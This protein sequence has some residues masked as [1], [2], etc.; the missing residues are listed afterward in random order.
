M[1]APRRPC[2]QPR[3]AQPLREGGGGLRS[4]SCRLL[5]AVACRCLG[6]FVCETEEAPTSCSCCGRRLPCALCNVVC[7]KPPGQTVCRPVLQTSNG[8]LMKLKE[9][10]QACLRSPHSPVAEQRQEPRVLI[11]SF[12]FEGQHFQSIF[13]NV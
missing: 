8:G 5:C 9:K 13:L 4:E 11:Y 2:E 6:V 10:S 7:G 3:G 1:E 12:L